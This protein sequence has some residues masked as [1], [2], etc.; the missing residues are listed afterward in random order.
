[1]RA[2][3]AVVKYAVSLAASGC[4]LATLLRDDGRPEAALEWYGKASGTLEGVLRQ[5]SRHRTA[6]D[7]LRNVSTG[8]ARA[9]SLLGRH[10]DAVRDWDRAIELAAGPLRAQFG[11][12][13]AHALAR[14][15]DLARALTTANELAGREDLTGEDL[16]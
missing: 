3:P 13:R 5:Q 11:C 4:N 8:R 6:Q 9:F 7:F 14:T 15:G 1:V 2:H 16:L 10:A 12:V